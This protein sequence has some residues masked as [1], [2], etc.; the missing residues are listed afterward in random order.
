[1]KKLI[2]IL[3]L[4]LCL[5][6]GIVLFGVCIAGARN[7]IPSEVVSAEEIPTENPSNSDNEDTSKLIDKVKELVN[8]DYFTTTILP[9]LTTGGCGLLGFLLAIIPLIKSRLKNKKAQD[10]LKN[11][12]NLISELKAENE[13]LIATVKSLDV[14]A[15]NEAFNKFYENL[16]K[17]I[18][19]IL[20]DENMLKLMTETLADV[21]CLLSAAII[22]WGGKNEAIRTMLSTTNFDGLKET[23]RKVELLEKTVHS[24]RVEA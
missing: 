11:A 13:K 20:I 5:I 14:N 6:L 4:G 16:P 19:K 9:I 7:A 1:M 15:L 23:L 24:E 8:K 12:D 3:G 18:Q 17:S 10:E 22:A 21:K 2:K